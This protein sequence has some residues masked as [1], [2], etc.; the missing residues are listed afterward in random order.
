M[1]PLAEIERLQ[2]EGAIAPAR[3]SPRLVF[4]ARLEEME[5]ILEALREAEKGREE[6]LSA[7]AEEVKALREEME[8]RAEE[9]R[10][11]RRIL[12][13]LLCLLLVA[14]VALVV[15]LLWRV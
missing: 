6:R 13:L 5:K 10:R 1:I 2:K 4:L 8:R 15:L 3:P 9:E 7:L 11:G 14:V 12:L